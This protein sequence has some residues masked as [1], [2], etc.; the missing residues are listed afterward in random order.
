MK[1][2]TTLTFSLFLTQRS[3]LSLFLLATISL[4]MDAKENL[5]IFD[6]M[7]VFDLEWASDPRVSPD[8]SSIVY[9]SDQTYGRF[10][11]MAMIIDHFTQV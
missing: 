7:D 1:L 2:K 8:G 9:V 6:P 5:A 11:A 4:N 10:Q 3:L